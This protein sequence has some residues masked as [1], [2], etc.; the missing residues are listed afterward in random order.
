MTHARKSLDRNGRWADLPWQT[1]RI[2]NPLSGSGMRPAAGCLKGGVGRRGK[3]DDMQG[4][5]HWSFR[6]DEILA[7]GRGTCLPRWVDDKDP[8]KARPLQSPLVFS[9]SLSRHTHIVVSCSLSHPFAGSNSLVV[10]LE[11]RR[12]SLSRSLPIRFPPLDSILYFSGDPEYD[13]HIESSYHTILKLSRQGGNLPP[14]AFPLS[15]VV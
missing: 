9:C 5:V 13:S 12:K 2:F 10:W 7:E 14:P 4:A 15:T 3:A 11:V 8:H 1:K 6:A